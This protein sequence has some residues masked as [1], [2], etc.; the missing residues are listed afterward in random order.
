MNCSG[1]RRATSAT[2]RP[3][4]ANRRSAPS[5]TGSSTRCSASPIRGGWQLRLWWKPFVTLIW[6][7][8]ALIAFG[9][10][11]ALLGRLWRRRARPNGASATHEP[12]RP[13]RA[14]GAARPDRARRWCG[15]WR[16]RPA[17]MSVAGLEGRPVPAFALAGGGARQAGS[18]L[19]RSRDRQAAAAQHLRELVRPMHRRG[20]VLAASSSEQGVAIDGIAVRDRPEESPPS[21]RRTATRMSGSERRAE[22]SP[23]RTGFVGSARKLR[24]RWQ[25]VIRYQ[26]SGRSSQDVPGILT[27]LEQAR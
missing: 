10:A 18:V 13:L 15:G 24:H 6:A 22:P 27:K 8:G 1:R 12:R 26:Q 3:R 11:L 5:G 20:Q 4:R 17:R 9:G 7:G 19:G 21:S 16:R 2:R 23:D 25:G 14:F